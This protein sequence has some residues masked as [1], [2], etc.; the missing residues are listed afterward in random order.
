MR[1]ATTF[2][3]SKSDFPDESEWKSQL[4][5]CLFSGLCVNVFLS[6]LENDKKTWN[7]ELF[8]SDSKQTRNMLAAIVAS[9]D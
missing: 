5:W 1:G 8:E 7:S 9:L 6:V 3:R 4:L 2:S